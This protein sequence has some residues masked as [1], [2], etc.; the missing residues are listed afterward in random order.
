MSKS[1]L[2]NIY[3]G[4]SL[5]SSFLNALTKSITAIYD[6]G[7]RVGS[8]LFRNTSGSLCR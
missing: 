2:T 3:G 8:A 5:T 1:D 6:L 4:I 7:R